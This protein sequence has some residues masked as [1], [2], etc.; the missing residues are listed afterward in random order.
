MKPS[1]IVLKEYGDGRDAKTSQYN[2]DLDFSKVLYN[3]TDEDCTFILN[4]ILKNI[5]SDT[6]TELNTIEVYDI[7][8]RGSNRIVRIIMKDINGNQN[9]KIF[10]IVYDIE[11]KYLSITTNIGELN[12]AGAIMI[13]EYFKNKQININN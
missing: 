8:E 9:R 6:E 10:Q 1:I 11:T 4:V 12:T 3:L 5:M 13:Y 7:F 2:Y